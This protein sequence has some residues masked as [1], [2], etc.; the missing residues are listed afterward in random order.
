MSK[1]LLSLLIVT[2]LLLAAAPAF[3]AETYGNTAAVAN[4]VKATRT[5]LK[6]QAK[7]VRTDLKA[8]TQKLNAD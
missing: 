2:G 1:K 8:T 7:Q 6:A 3:A 5:E 4:P